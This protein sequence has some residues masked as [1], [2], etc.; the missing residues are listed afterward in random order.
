MPEIIVDSPASCCSP[1]LSE[2]GI[3]ESQLLGPDPSCLAREVDERPPK[4]GA[5]LTRTYHELIPRP[6]PPPEPH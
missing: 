4:R 2:G 6:L 5:A 1:L 3:Q